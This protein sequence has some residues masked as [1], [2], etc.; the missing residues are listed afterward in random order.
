MVTVKFPSKYIHLVALGATMCALVGCRG[1][2]P[3]S[4]VTV[5]IRQPGISYEAAQETVRELGYAIVAADS[6]ARALRVVAKTERTDT[7]GPDSRSWIDLHVYS[8]GVDARACGQLAQVGGRRAR[9]DLRIEMNEL[10][11]HIRANAEKLRTA[12]NAS[13]GHQPSM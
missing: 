10:L 7:L 6:R 11:A 1:F 13:V 5:D 2:G 8:Q 12:E 4:Q 3:A 9:N